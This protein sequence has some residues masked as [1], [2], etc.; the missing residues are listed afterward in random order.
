[1][2]RGNERGQGTVEWV[3]LVAIVA[4]LLVAFVAG[5]GGGGGVPGA[6]LA[7]PIASRLLCAAALADS[8]GDEP[9]LIAAYGKEVGR[10]VRGHMP[11][12]LVARRSPPP[13]PPPPPRAAA[14]APRAAGGGRGPGERFRPP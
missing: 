1:M 12:L 4:L 6:A 2:R 7:R 3:G 10:L 11:S 8:C 14:P 5:G 13:P 9:R